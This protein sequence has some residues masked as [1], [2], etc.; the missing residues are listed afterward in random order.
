MA[1]D[2]GSV[3]EL[4]LQMRQLGQRT[5][6]VW[7]YEVGGALGDIDPEGLASA[8][9]SFV[10]PAYRAMVGTVFGDAFFSV[11]LRDLSDPT[12]VALE[13]PIPVGQRV[14][15]R[16]MGTQPEEQPSFLAVGVRLTVATRATRPGQKRFGF[17]LELDTYQNGITSGMMGLVTTFMNGMD[18]EI[19]LAA[20]SL[21]TSLHPVVVRRA[22]DGSIAAFQRVTGHVVNPNSTTQNSRKAG[23]GI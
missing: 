6:N 10:S 14:G 11:L 15:T 8:W 19:V 2:N 3:I 1:I 5:M 16:S 22:A 13:L 17:L 18:H 21:G 12:G 23:R 4:S 20:P 7:Q 9:W